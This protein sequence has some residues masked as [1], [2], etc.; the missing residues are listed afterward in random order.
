MVSTQGQA[1]DDVS[2]DI[3]KPRI[4]AWAASASEEV[5]SA[6][7]DALEREHVASTRLVL[8]TEESAKSF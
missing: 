8:R 2:L 6:H 3:Q 1:H 7:S 5:V 4:L